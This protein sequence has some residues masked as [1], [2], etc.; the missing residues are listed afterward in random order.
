M[1]RIE[2]A[3]DHWS[4]RGARSKQSFV[5]FGVNYTPG[6][7]GWPPDYLGPARF[8]AARIES[9]FRI[10][11]S[12]GVNVC[13]VVLPSIRMVPDPQVPGKKAR[14]NR[15][16]LKRFD[17][18]LEIA[19]R[20]HIRVIAT[21]ELGWL[22]APK[23][24]SRNGIW[25]GEGNVD[26]LGSFWEQFASVHKG[27]GRILAYSFCVETDLYGWN[28]PP[29][30][31]AWRD[32]A[33]RRYRTLKAANDTWGTT[34]TRWAS[35]PAAGYDGHNSSDWRNHPEGTDQNE[36]NTGDQFL[37]DYLQ[38]REFIAFRHVWRQAQ[39]VKQA[40]SHALCTMGFV[41]W[42]PLLRNYGGPFNDSP[43]QGPEY[44]AREIGRA[45]DFV[46]IH[47][48]PVYPNGAD[49][50][51]LKY[52]ELWARWADIGKPVLLEEFNMHPA[53]RNLTWCPK[54]IDHSIRYVSG[55]LCW[56]FQNVPNSDDVTKVCGMVD[57]DTTVTAWG[58]EFAR[59]AQ[60]VRSRVR[61]EKPDRTA[62]IDK[63]FLFTSGRYQDVI[64]DLMTSGSQ[65][66]RFEM[67]PNPAID[68]LMRKGRPSK[69]FAELPGSLSCR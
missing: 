28:C 61:R 38:F 37:Y 20:H 53:E 46:A 60:E 11:E 56:T 25:Y 1:E 58:R 57:G 13:K 9:D 10:M 43:G 27:D 35:V 65:A 34:F 54:V 2:I 47:F 31:S 24:F 50:E 45:L 19:G 44:N 59:I 29:A 40:D 21:L 23:W 22:G 68:E 55:W 49:E 63:R 67:D 16:M 14:I 69:S 15:A 62:R 26:I 64:R 36:N 32:W 4:F 51:Q 3:P 18:L 6:W 48:Y 17:K 39:A 7:A 5:P 30:V 66:V 52:L 41:Q 42:N 12:L 8:D 33:R